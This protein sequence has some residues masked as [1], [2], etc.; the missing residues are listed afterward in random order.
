MPST[1]PESQHLPGS[2]NLFDETRLRLADAETLQELRDDLLRVSF[3]RRDVRLDSGVQQP[4]FFDK[5]LMASRPSILRRLARFLAADVPAGTD[6]LA[7]PTLGA[8]AFGTAVSLETGL[9]LALV[10]THWDGTRG[11]AAIE[12]GPHRGE[13]VVLIEDVV[14]SG[15]RALHAVEQLR[16]AGATVV[17]VVAA[18]D[19]ERGADAAM[20]GQGV[21]Y[22]PLFRFSDFSSTRETR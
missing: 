4:Y 18:I 1:D 3:Q 21:D 6:R 10:R 11:S 8:V 9:P 16:S 15:T 7:A 12:G 19:C 17:A 2:L 22:V 20:G 5:Y 14:V 13:T